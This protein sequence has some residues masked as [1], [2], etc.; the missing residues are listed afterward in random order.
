MSE[1][2]EEALRKEYEWALQQD[3]DRYMDV[4]TLKEMIQSMDSKAL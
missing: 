1:E 4:K 2:E 3:K